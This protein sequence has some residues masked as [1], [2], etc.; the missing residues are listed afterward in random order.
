[1]SMRMCVTCVSALYSFL[2]KLIATVVVLIKYAYVNVLL[3]LL[4][5][6]LLFLFNLS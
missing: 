5:F 3:L 6:I 2:T 4:L 1:M